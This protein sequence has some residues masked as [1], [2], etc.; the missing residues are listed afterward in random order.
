MKLKYLFTAILPALLFTGCSEDNDPVGPLGDI[1]LSDTYAIIPAEGGETTVKIVASSEWKVTNVAIDEQTG[2]QVIAENGEVKRDKNGNATEVWFTLSQLSG[3]AGNEGQ[4]FETELKI[5]ADAVDGGREYEL[6]ISIGGNT[7]FLMIRQG[8]MTPVL[9]S[10]AE[11]LAGPDGKAYKVKGV[12]TAIANTTYGN[13]YLND[14]TGELYVYGTLDAD[15][16]EKNFES[17]GI[18]VGDEIEL[19]G[20]KK[21]YN[22][23]VQL[24]NVTVTKINKALLKIITPETTISNEAQEFG[25]KVAF[26]GKGAYVDVPEEAKSWLRYKTTEFIAGVPTKIERNPADTAVFKFEIVENSDIKAVRSCELVF[27]SANSS[28][29]TTMTY[30]VRQGIENKTI[31]AFNALPDNAKVPYRIEGI[32]TKIE[33]D[34]YGNI[35]VKDATGEAYVYGTLTPDGQSKQF[36]T[37]GLKV[38]DVITIYGPKVSYKGAPQMTNGTYESH[39]DVTPVTVAEFRNVPDNKN[40]YYMLTGKVGEPTE[41]GTL[42]DLKTYGNFNLTDAS[43]SVYVYGVVPGWNGE[44]KIFN[45]LGIAEGDEVT[46]LAYKTTYKGLVEAVGVYY[47]HKKAE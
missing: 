47:S 27:S 15:G 5:S 38:G 18:E 26:K 46:I 24:V 34:L 39:L 43:G 8:S 31:A 7:Q 44:K 11:V 2:K 35:R 29:K 36:G 28:G 45:T 22:G 37:L 42:Y 40:K 3:K 30:F 13:W 19:E 12:C 17:L 32:I 25:V 4:V 41:A 23:T 9:A 20:P 14:G 6:Q 16:A 21:T 1:S 33:S 10:C